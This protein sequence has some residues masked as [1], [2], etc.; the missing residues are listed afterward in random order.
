VGTHWEPE[1]NEKIN[2]NPL[3]PNL[4]KKKKKSKAP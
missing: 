4:K 2:K 3:P 1:K